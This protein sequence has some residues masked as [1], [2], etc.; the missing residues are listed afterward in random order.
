MAAVLNGNDKTFMI[1][2]EALAEKITMSIY[3]SC[4]AQ[5]AMLTSE[6]NGI[7]AEYSN[8]S[9]IFSSNS[10]AELPEYTTINDHP[11]DL[12]DNK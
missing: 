10:A 8:F 4:Q 1:Y 5:I 12:L 6:E 11:I 3:P 9:N 2:V 7:P